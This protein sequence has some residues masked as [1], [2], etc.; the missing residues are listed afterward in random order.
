MTMDSIITAVDS[1]K[2]SH[3]CQY[4]PN[5]SRVSSYIESRGGQFKT[6]R[7]F[8][9]QAILKK[10]FTK[11]I[12]RHEVEEAQEL[13]RLHGVPFNRTGWMRIADVHEGKLPLIIEAVPEGTDVPTGN[14]LVQVRNTNPESAWLTSY[15][16]TV[17]M[18]VWYPITVCTLSAAIR[19]VLMEMLEESCDDPAAVIPFLLHDFGCR[20]VS[21]MESAA[22]GGLAHLVNFRGTDTVPAILAGRMYY[23]EPMAGYSIPAMEH[24]TVTAWGRDGEGRAFRN[25]LQQFGGQ[26]KT[27][28]M[29]VD[30]Y[31][32]DYAVGSIIGDD[33][34]DEIIN[35]GTRVIVRP[36][37]GDPRTVVP[38]VLR[39]LNDRFGGENNHK[40]YRVL[41]PS[42]R[43]IQGDGMSLESIRET[44]A[45]ILQARFSAENVT[46]GLGGGL[47]QKLDRDTMRFAMKASAAEIDW[48]WHDVYKDPKDDQGKRSKRGR[49]ALTYNGTEWSDHKIKTGFETVRLEELGE[50]HNA[51]RRVYQNGRLLIDE[52]LATIRARAA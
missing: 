30:S 38:R 48:I 49:L 47:L 46:Y 24:S 26:G 21:S 32:L 41:H 17:L 2:E 10:Y 34:R 11:R 42:V 23:D 45:A 4:P 44:G 9:L 3:F 35:S 36:D 33:L 7:F 28:A 37:S 5:T 16:E 27:I 43:V 50:R 31:D 14:V 18:Q 13:F 20:G 15:V 39:I 40:G 19:A 52:T 51:L 12:W 6:T 8:G 29:V 1:Y 22:L 25:M